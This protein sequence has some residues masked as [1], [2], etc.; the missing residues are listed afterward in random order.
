[1]LAAKVSRVLFTSVLLCFGLSVVPRLAAQGT[2]AAARKTDLSVFAGVATNSTGVLDERNVGVSTGFAFTRY[3]P[4]VISPALDARAVVTY[5]QDVRESAYLV[6]PRAQFRFHR[7]FKP[8]ADFLLGFGFIHVNHPAP[9]GLLGVRAPVDA[10]GGGL[11]TEI[12]RNFDLK[13]DYQAQ[14][15]IISV[16]NIPHPSMFT[17]GVTYHIP[18]GSRKAR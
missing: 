9:G 4:F 5:G 13:L 16:D 6:G 8:Y 1:M 10:W 11:D 7:R 14:V 12:S 3:V 15:R 2:P 17:A 18:F